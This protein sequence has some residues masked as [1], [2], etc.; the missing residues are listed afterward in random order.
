MNPFYFPNAVTYA[1]MSRAVGEGVAK[2]AYFNGETD[3]FQST[4]EDRWGPGSYSRIINLSYGFFGIRALAYSAFKS[5]T[6]RR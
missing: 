5:L 4:L 6:S 3:E 2:E 1:L